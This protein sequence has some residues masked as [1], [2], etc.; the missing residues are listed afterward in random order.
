MPCG[1]M[2]I[3]HPSHFPPCRLHEKAR[4]TKGGR[5][6]T[7]EKEQKKKKKRRKAS[8]TRHTSRAAAEP[9]HTHFT[10]GLKAKT[11]HPTA[12]EG[13]RTS[14][15]EQAT[16][17][18]TVKTST[19]EEEGA[20]RNQMQAPHGHQLPLPF[21]A[22]R[23]HQNFF[24]SSSHVLIVKTTSPPTILGV[25]FLS[26]TT[27]V[28]VLSPARQRECVHARDVMRRQESVKTASPTVVCSPH[29]AAEECFG[30]S[31]LLLSRHVGRPR[32][33]RNRHCRDA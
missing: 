19:K 30:L 9:P 5:G 17:T 33:D 32:A 23:G 2:P 11:Q 31:L 15:T 28:Y 16:R 21:G 20:E 6:E 14:R 29:A 4:Q 18:A 22:A 25:Y 13:L 26:F 3:S 24:F 1:E 10:S 7:T 27:R 12:D 8:C